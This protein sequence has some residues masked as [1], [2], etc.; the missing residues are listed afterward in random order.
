MITPFKGSLHV[1]ANLQV[2][3]QVIAS[4]GTFSDSLTISGTPVKLSNAGEQ[5]AIQFTLQTGVDDTY[6]L[7]QH[8]PLPFTVDI[9]VRQTDAGTVSGSV[10]IEGTP[11]TGFSELVFSTTEA[12]STATGG[13]TVAVG[14]KI[15]LVLSGTSSAEMVSLGLVG[16]KL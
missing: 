10:N 5:L 1:T 8:A 12:T 16:T 11:I 13:N 6:T 4:S 7:L 14:D 15:T 3:G 2:D 9:A